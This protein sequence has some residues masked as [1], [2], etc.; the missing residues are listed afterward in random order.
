MAAVMW[1]ATHPTAAAA[2]AAVQLRLHGLERHI[3]V[4]PPWPNSPTCE[5]SSVCESLSAQY[6][7]ASQLST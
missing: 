7:R 2:A 5:S 3:A 1:L 4:F 6:V